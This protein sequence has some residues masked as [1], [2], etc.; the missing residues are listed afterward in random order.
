MFLWH[1]FPALSD[2]AL[3]GQTKAKFIVVLSTS[4]SDDPIVFVLTTSLKPK[5]ASVAHPEDY[6]HVPIGS[7]SFLGSETLIDVSEAGEFDVGRDEFQALYDNG[8]LLFKGQLT[9]SHVEQL[10][11]MI[12]ACP[13]VPR[14]FKRILVE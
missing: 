2:P 13:R 3:A 6:L 9:D 10:I 8:D 11:R 5:H 12:L 4:A 14:R 7:Y 1:K